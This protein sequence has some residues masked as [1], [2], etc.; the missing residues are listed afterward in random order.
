V[1]TVEF[2]ERELVGIRVAFQREFAF[3]VFLHL[4]GRSRGAVGVLVRIEEYSVR[5]VVAGAPVRM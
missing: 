1:L 5:E 2:L 4:L 3:F